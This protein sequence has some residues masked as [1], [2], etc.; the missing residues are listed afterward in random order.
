MT[1]TVPLDDRQSSQPETLPAATQELAHPTKS[2]K[3]SLLKK[4]RQL[5]K[6]KQPRKLQQPWKHQQTHSWKQPNPRPQK[7]QLP[8]AWF[9]QAATDPW[10][11]QQQMVGLGWRA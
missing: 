10:Q 9:P 6:L 2:L 1:E 5:G 11:P 3:S 8:Q 7:Q 4:L